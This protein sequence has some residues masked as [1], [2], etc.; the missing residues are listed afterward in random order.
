METKYVDVLA[1]IEAAAQLLDLH[2]ES[3]A[4]RLRAAAKRIESAREKL[5]RMN[6]VA[7]NRHSGFGDKENRRWFYDQTAEALSLIG[8]APAAQVTP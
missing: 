6:E 5:D 4:S 2:D 1:D 7:A 3:R 8:R